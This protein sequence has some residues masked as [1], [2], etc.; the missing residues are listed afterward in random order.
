MNTIL[1]NLKT[2]LSTQFSTTFKKYIIGRGM[3]EKFPT[4]SCPALIIT[5]VSTAITNSGTVKDQ[6][7]FTIRVAIVDDIKAYID[8]INGAW[9]QQDATVQHYTWFEDRNSDGSLKAGTILG[10]IRDNIELSGAVLFNN[11]LTVEYDI[12]PEGTKLISQVTF[13]ALTRSTR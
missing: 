10:V 3:F 8:N 11:E 13:Q 5:G 6:N 2:L 4:S 9:E 1:T 7:L 12:D